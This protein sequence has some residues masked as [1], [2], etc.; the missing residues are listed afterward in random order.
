MKIINFIS[1]PHKY[2]SCGDF[3]FLIFINSPSDFLWVFDQVWT[4]S[5][6][7]CRRFRLNICLSILGFV[8]ISMEPKRSSE[9][10][11]RHCL[12]LTAVIDLL[13]DF[14]SMKGSG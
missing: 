5:S 6:W 1:I 8:L 14:L 9:D 10:I 12:D 11:A 4:D 13:Y 2:I 3:T 7:T